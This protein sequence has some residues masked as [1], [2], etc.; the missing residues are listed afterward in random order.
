[1]K[2]EQRPIREQPQI[3]T[4]GSP[5]AAKSAG[6]SERLV[7]ILYRLKMSLSDRSDHQLGDPLTTSDTDG[8]TAAILHNDADLSSI[9]TVDRSRRI[10]QVQSVAKRQPRARAD[11]SLKTHGHRKGDTGWDQDPVT[12]RKF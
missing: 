4:S 11:L 12:R 3:Q 9:V 10:G 8:L 6:S 7:E 2:P 1:V 5:C